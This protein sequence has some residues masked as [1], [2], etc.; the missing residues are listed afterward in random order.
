MPVGIVA[1]TVSSA[2]QMNALLA[3]YQVRA[4][5]NSS[6]A[7]ATTLT[8]LTGWT[9]DR[10]DP[11]GF[12]AATGVFTCPSGFSGSWMAW[13]QVS[14]ASSS[15]RRVSTI[16]VGTVEKAR[17][18]DPPSSAGRLVHTVQTVEPLELAVGDTVS[19]QCA[20]PSSATAL[21][22]AFATQLLMWKIG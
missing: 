21:D 1:G 10:D 18:D 12:D 20:S 11:G 3:L 7:I 17:M 2:A 5:M 15:L 4:S 16:Y 19:V 14:F 8:T 22:S 13:A 9:E 6:Q